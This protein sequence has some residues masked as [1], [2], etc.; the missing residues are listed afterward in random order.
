MGAYTYISMRLLT[1]MKAIGRGG[2]DLSD[3]KYVGRLPSA[4]TATGF[5]QVH[6]EEQTQLLQK[7]LQLE[8]VSYP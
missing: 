1:A 8:P 6:V 3:V 5:Y 4:A 7:A 2:S